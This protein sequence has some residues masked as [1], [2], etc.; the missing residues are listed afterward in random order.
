MKGII[1][2]LP[3]SITVSR[4]IMTFVFLYFIT[5]QFIYGK[6]GY[7]PL[8]LAFIAICI[9]DLIDG[10]LA[11]KMRVTSV[12]GAKLDVFTDLL[13]IVVSYVALINFK[14]LPI[15]FLVFVCLKFT[16]FVITS[17]LIKQYSN[18]N[19]VFIFDKV[20]KIVSA[21]FLVIPG[22]ACFLKCASMYN[23]E[24]LINCILYF[25]AVGGIYSSYL[26]IKTCI[27]IKL[28]KEEI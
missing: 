10:K 21:L 7:V 18:S 8:M 16:E 19:N 25:M 12:L 14:V 28:A 23:F 11:R 4:I 9:S 17:K 3:N 6:W 20:G 13:Y 1:K 15:W 5:E 27:S 24:S 2:L 22:V 26:R